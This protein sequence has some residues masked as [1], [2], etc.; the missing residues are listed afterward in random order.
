MC[1]RYNVTAFHK[2]GEDFEIWRG[3]FLMPA[4]EKILA[5]LFFGRDK[6]LRIGSTGVSLYRFKS[7]YNT[8]ECEVA[9]YCFSIYK[10]DAQRYTRIKDSKHYMLLI[11]ARFSEIVPEHCPGKELTFPDDTNEWF[12]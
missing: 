4:E 5:W 12:R 10:F 1:Y 8:P 7:V 11:A 9:K 6:N 3:G 2:N